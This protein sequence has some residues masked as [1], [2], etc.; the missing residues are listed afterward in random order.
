MRFFIASPLVAHSDITLPDDVAHH[1]VRVLRSEAGTRFVLFNG[2]GG[3]FDAELIEAGKK[4]ARARLLDFHPDNRQS[5]LLTHLG[6]V[7]SKGDRMDF[8]IQKATELG[9]SEITPLTSERCELRLRGEERADK[10]LEHWRR[11][12]ISAC[13]QCGRN[14]VP[15]VH[16]PVALADWSAKVQA[17]LKLVLAPAVSGRLPDGRVR[18]AAL[19]VGPEGGLSEAEI[20]AVQAQGFLPWQLGPRVL[21]TETAPLAALAVLQAELGDFS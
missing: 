7:M 2:E 17:E 5:P 13:E 6:Q 9:V 3:A 14:L 12:A 20:A 21:R 16:E 1:L 4:T 10:K 18:S 8:A 19:L 15:V 11:V